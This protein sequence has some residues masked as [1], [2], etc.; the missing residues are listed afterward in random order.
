M[1]TPLFS[2]IGEIFLDFRGHC[3]EKNSF[4][5][6]SVVDLLFLIFVDASTVFFLSAGSRKN[7][8]TPESLV[9]IC[10]SIPSILP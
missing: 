9:Q 1:L 8:G 4:R 2:F 10:S 7:F 3:L 6:I 5:I